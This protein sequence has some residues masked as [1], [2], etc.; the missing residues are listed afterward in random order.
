MMLQFDVLRLQN[1]VCYFVGA[2]CD[3]NCNYWEII[4]HL[5]FHEV[6]VSAVSYVSNGKFDYI[7]GKT[8]LM[9]PH[10]Q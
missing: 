3:E 7:S 5:I 6:I 9:M 8:Y 1:Y 10:R 2:I 4:F